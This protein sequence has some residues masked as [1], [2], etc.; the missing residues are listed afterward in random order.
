MNTDVPHPRLRP[1]EIFPIQHDGQ[2]MFALRDPEGFTSTAVLPYGG[3]L[4]ATLMDG[5][6]SLAQLQDAFRQQ[7]GHSVSLLELQRLV[8][9]LGEAL[10]L[11]DERFARRRDVQ[12]ADYLAAPVRPAA[13]AG[14]A[15]ADQP[16]ALRAQ[17]D[18]LFTHES[19]PGAVDDHANVNANNGNP[20]GNGDGPAPRLRGVLSP[21]IDLHRGGPAFAWAYKR[22]A[23][24]SDAD[25]FVVFGTAHGPMRSL[26][27]VSRKDFATPL[28]RVATDQQ[29]IDHLAAAWDN[30]EGESAAPIGSLFDD[31][32]AHRNEHSIEFQVLFLQYLFGEQRPFRVV[33]ILTGS[34]HQLI[35]T[36]REPLEH[37][38]VSRMVESLRSAEPQFTEATGRRVA[39]VSGGDLAHIGQ[40]FGDPDLLTPERLDA[41]S[42]SDHTLLER[43]CR[44]NAADFF[45]HV[46]E[47]ADRNRIC[48]LSPTYTMLCAMGSTT[49]ELLAYDQAVE[50]DGSS[51]VSFASAAFYQA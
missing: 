9:N 11:D 12:L 48:G 13:H 33:P 5:T 18:A 15:Y 34:F 1:L 41:Q 21:H 14:G 43:A 49:G 46:A 7:S 6:R 19:G 37:P 3:A 29:Y 23:E 50:R 30:A 51:C 47:E 10:L 36:R 25:T 45:A 2:T 20:T 40:R 24:Q 42:Q 17:L 32:P 35:A 44:G 31:E 22:L 38:A 16:T 39:Y 4:L 26:F 28:G 27:S 8:A